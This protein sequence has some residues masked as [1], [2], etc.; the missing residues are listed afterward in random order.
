MSELSEHLEAGR[1][2]PSMVEREPSSRAETP[3]VASALMSMGEASALLGVSTATLR[4]WSSDGRIASHA[5]AGG[6]RRFARSTVEA[7]L[8][9]APEVRAAI[10]HAATADRIH[11]AYRES[12]LSDSAA[13]AFLDGVPSG[14]RG[15]LRTYGWIITSSILAC[16]EAS[17]DESRDAALAEG[18]VAAAAYGRI[19]RTAG[20]SMRETVA[21]FLRFRTP[22]VR[23]MAGAARREGLDA[24]G[25]TDLLETVTVA[26][27][28]LLDATLEG[29][30][31]VTAAAPPTSARRSR[32][33]AASPAAVRRPESRA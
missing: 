18:L 20:A 1:S 33:A 28:R 32:A 9:R 31:Q 12:A 15:G 8:P 6:H 10:A 7:L 17:D 2:G 11:R 16:L 23:E 19:A 24:N 22:F 14:A 29:Y 5:T 21:A 3:A 27:D 25:A 4:R 26:I 30:E 13:P